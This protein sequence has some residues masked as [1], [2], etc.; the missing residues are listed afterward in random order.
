MVTQFIILA[1][2]T[3]FIQRLNAGG[4]MAL[5]G[6]ATPLALSATVF[7]MYM[8]FSWIGNVPAS[9]IIGS[10]LPTNLPLLMALL[11]SLS[12]LPLFLVRFIKPYEVGKAVKV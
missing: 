3:N 10:L 2:L 8:S 5:M 11:S 9:V 6:D 4:R 1:M 7:Q 12:I